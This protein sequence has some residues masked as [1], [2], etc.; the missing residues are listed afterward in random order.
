MLSP[1]IP[2]SWATYP[3]SGS[4][5]SHDYCGQFCGTGLSVVVA[6]CAEAS[7]GPVLQ[8]LLRAAALLP[9]SLPALSGVAPLSFL[10]LLFEF[11]SFLYIVAQR[12]ETPQGSQER[13]D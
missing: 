12:V 1:G 3:R 7:D 10:V 13:A 6:A 8:V 11:F 4:G 5:G 9:G 2:D